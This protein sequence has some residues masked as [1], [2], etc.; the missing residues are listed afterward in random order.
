MTDG[1]TIASRH[2]AFGSITGVGGAESAGVIE[3]EINGGMGG[4]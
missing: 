1:R 4:Y 3:L 2:S